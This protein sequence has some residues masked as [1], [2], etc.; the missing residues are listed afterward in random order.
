MRTEKK[1]FSETC[2][3][4]TSWL[5]VKKPILRSQVYQMTLQLASVCVYVLDRSASAETRVSRCQKLQKVP[6]INS[7]TLK[8]LSFQKKLV[9]REKKLWTRA[10]RCWIRSY[11]QSI[12]SFSK[13]VYALYRGPKLDSTV[14]DNLY[15]RSLKWKLKCENILECEL[16]MFAETTKCKKVI[17]DLE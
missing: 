3:S 6:T 2:K 16:A 14:N 5:Q 15:N 8:M 9:N 17:G 4:L 11:Y 13:H 12:S 7:K 10:E 1:V